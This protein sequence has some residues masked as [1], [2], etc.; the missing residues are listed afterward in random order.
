M[1]KPDPI[2]NIPFV[3]RAFQNAVE[4]SMKPGG[5]DVWWESLISVMRQLIEMWS[6]GHTVSVDN[7]A[8]RLVCHQCHAKLGTRVEFDNNQF[9]TI[10]ERIRKPCSN[11][12]PWGQW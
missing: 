4:A 9:Q 2:E 11:P 8:D 6:S 3:A 1:S 10:V 5:D 7:Y 12:K